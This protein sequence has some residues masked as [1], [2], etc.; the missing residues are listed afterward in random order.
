MDQRGNPTFRFRH[1]LPYPRYDADLAI[2]EPH[3]H[4]AV[5]VLKDGHCAGGTLSARRLMENR[6][7]GGGV[8]LTDESTTADFFAGLR[9]CPLLS[10]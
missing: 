3:R 7:Y 9:Y 10:K 6:S 5:G 1:P 8:A 4:E 2:I